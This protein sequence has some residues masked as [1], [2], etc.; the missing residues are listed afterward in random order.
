ME[1]YLKKFKISDIFQPKLFELIKKRNY[2]KKDFTADLMAGIIVGIVALP[3]AIA[4]GIA[5]GVSPQQGLITAIIAGFI[6]SF[7]GGTK[8]LIGGPTGAFMVIV[9]GIV[10]EYG[11][12]GLIIATIL[13]GIMLILMGVLK[14]GN[15]IKFIPYPI[16]VGFT[17]GIAVVI[18]TSQIKDFF[19][20]DMGAVPSEF[21]DK[22]TAYF[23]H[24]ISANL[25]SV[26]LAVFTILAIIFW[27][28]KKIPGS[29]I[30]II[31][32]TVLTAVFGLNVETIGS[33][34]PELAGGAA[35]PSPEAPIIDMKAIRMLFQPAFTIAMLAAIESLLAAMVADG[36]TGKKHHS[37][38]ELIAQ[39]IANILT[40]IFGGIPATGAIARTMTNINNG[41]RTPIAGIIHAIV[42]LLIFVCL[43]PLA[44]YIPL[45]CLAGILIM[46]AYNMSEWR[47]F[48]GLLRNSRADVLVLLTTFFLTVFIDLTIAI[49]FGLLMAV[50]LFLKR[51]S[52]TSSISV[53]QNE[54]NRSDYDDSAEK[55][56]LNIP[57]GVE[58]YEIN[59]PFFFG[60]ANK[61]DEAEHISV[62]K[63]PK[64]RILRMRKVPFMDSTGLH[65]LRNLCERCKHWKIRIILSGVNKD[66]FATL[67]KSG[68]ANEIGK[69]FICNN[70]EN[71]LKKAKEILE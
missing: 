26:G 53:I 25:M 57:E 23:E 49:E 29:L 36:V 6:I 2:T 13:A 69:K 24:F 55:E 68:L 39:G 54:I 17:S 34:F 64:I 66:V 12:N 45:P 15:I 59:G 63:R 50:I 71:A 4:F 10:V 60:L 61:F 11:M 41:G 33:K 8:V 70:I 30:A 58:V 1:S 19:G 47:S 37:N 65:N 22:W 3:L 52:E 62:N 28:Y 32:A 46:V 14:L 51:V 5:S 21:I 20:L 48:K 31:I 67:E 44:S 16:V 35:L 9:Y 56:I 43:M 7:F 40:P 27:P 18:F 38:T 42:L